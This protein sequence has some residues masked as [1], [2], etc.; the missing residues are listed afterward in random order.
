MYRAEDEEGFDSWRERDLRPLRK[1]LSLAVLE[2]YNFD[3]VLDVGCGKGTFTHLLKRR[4]NHVLGIDVSPTAI[5][6][7]RQ[8]YPDVEFRQGD[9]RDLAAFGGGFDLVVTMGTLIYV[10]DWERVLEQAA[11][12]TRWLYVAE[13]V[14]AEPIG[15]VRSIA[16]LRAAV[17]RHFLP[18]T[19]LVLDDEHVMVLA[20]SRLAPPADGAP[21]PRS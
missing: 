2:A 6:K 15:F 20:W 19:T 10:R 8:S 4:N 7:A 9:A 16:D 11:R 3:R 18:H 17:E 13:H 1:R 5:R 12:L 14:P 21:P